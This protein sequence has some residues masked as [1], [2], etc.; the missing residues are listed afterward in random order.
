ML[1]PFPV[2]SPQLPYLIR[3]SPCFYEVFPYSP[4]PSLLP[5]LTFPYTGAL[6]L[7]RTKGFSSY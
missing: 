6:N 2:S 3:S 1:S 7:H 5:A 4:T